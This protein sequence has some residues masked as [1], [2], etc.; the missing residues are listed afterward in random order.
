M[1]ISGIYDSSEEVCLAANSENVKYMSAVY[2]LKK[3][4]LGAFPKL[5][6]PEE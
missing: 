3:K 5:E 1:Y 2:K 6:V 4:N